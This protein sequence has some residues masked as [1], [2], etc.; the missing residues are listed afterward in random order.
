[1]AGTVVEIDPE[2][3]PVIATGQG[4]IELVRVH[5]E[6]RRE[7]D[8]ASWLRGAGVRPGDVLQS[9]VDKR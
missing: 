3:G 6:G 2:R 9:A 4:L 1:M 8:A 5:P 7:M